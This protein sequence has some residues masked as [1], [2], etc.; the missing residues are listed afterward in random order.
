MLNH[1]HL[2]GQLKRQVKALRNLAIDPLPRSQ[3]V[4][5]ASVHCNGNVISINYEAKGE[6]YQI[7]VTFPE[8]Y[9]SELEGLPTLVK[10]QLFTLLGLAYTP[11]L[12]KLSDFSEVEVRTASLDA[13]SVGF[14][15]SFLRGGLGEFRYLQGLDPSRRIKLIATLDEGINPISVSPSD[16]LLM[17]NGGGKDTI[18]AA[19]M[20]KEAEQPFTWLSIRPNP[21]RRKVIALSGVP[22]ALEVFYELDPKINLNKVYKWGHLPHTSVVL[23]IGLIVAILRKSRYV[24][25]GNEH[26]ANFGNVIYKG[27]DVNHQYTKSFEFERGFQRFVSRRVVSDISVFSILRPYG[28]LQLAWMFSRHDEYFSHFISCNRGIGRGEGEWCKECPKCAFMALALFPFVGPDGVRAVFGENVLERPAIR[29]H[30]LQLVNGRI[31]PWECVGTKEECR[32]ALRLLLESNADMNFTQRPTRHDLEQA[33]GQDDIE[34]LRNRLLD[35][36][37]DEHLIPNELVHALNRGLAKGELTTL[38]I[39]PHATTE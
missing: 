36:A 31:K 32:L 23:S 9:S 7:Q 12:Y 5:L 1:S 2:A 30:I 11:F 33:A 3:R 6:T 4:T 27:F 8:C 14:F 25:A 10:S 38:A 28:D 21:T 39:R 16:D 13:E 26:S 18:V 20:L 17:L 37:H 34:E 19:E 29:R 24:A 35:H 22:E 15:E